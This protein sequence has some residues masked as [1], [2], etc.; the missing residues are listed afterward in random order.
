MKRFYSFVLI[1]VLTLSSIP[2]SVEAASTYISIESYVAK[3]CKTVGIGKGNHKSYIEAAIDN[4]IVTK[5][6]FS[7]TTRDIS[8]QQ[9][10][11]IA[12]R[13]YE[14]KYGSKISSEKYSAIINYSVI[15]DIDKVSTDLD[16]LVKCYARGIDVGYS[17]GKYTLSR[18]FRPTYKLTNKEAN[19]ICDRLA[20]N[21]K[22]KK[23]NI[24]GQVLRTDNLPSNYKQF[25][26]V[27]E[28]FPNSYYEKDFVYSD[29]NGALY[30]SPKDFNSGFGLAN[31]NGA[32][33]LNNTMMYSW[34]S[35]VAKNLKERL[36]INAETIGSAWINRVSDTYDLG[37][38]DDKDFAELLT[39]YVE[40]VIN[41]GT[42]VELK[43][44]SVDPGT[45]YVNNYVYYVRAYCK[46]V[47]K[48]SNVPSACILF[49]DLDA[50]VG[51]TVECV[52]DI[53]VQCVGQE[54]DGY[55]GY[56][57]M[58]LSGRDYITNK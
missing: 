55:S 38:C 41:D 7:D 57:V 32:F 39:Q 43:Q 50:Q 3:V 47:I 25:D 18:E 27:L 13:A 4:G 20:D 14:F 23:V 30:L 8:R 10:A 58:A 44:V 49:S 28:S 2:Y 31:K 37:L 21:S 29:D 12:N 56:A 5:N 42:V 35:Q 22:C 19:T 11:V 15:S 24:Y 9:A 26:Y 52:L 6:Q 40:D 45:T 1:L 36:N 33:S 51:E 48:S 34:A 17:N 16:Q 46:F 53:P 54:S